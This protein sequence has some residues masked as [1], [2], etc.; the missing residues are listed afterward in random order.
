MTLGIIVMLA[1]IILDVIMVV[2][3][4][5]VGAKHDKHNE[6]SSVKSSTALTRMKESGMNIVGTHLLR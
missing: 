6:T 4:M 3:V 2:V 5:R 1:I